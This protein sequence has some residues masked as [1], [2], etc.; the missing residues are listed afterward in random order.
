MALPSINSPVICDFNTTEPGAGSTDQ[1]NVSYVVPSFHGGFT[2]PCPPGAYN[3]TPGFT[4]CAGTDEAHDLAVL[5][6]KGMAVAGWKVLADDSV[7]KNV[8]DDFEEDKKRV[9]EEPY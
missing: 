5:T 8:W 1:G 9:G 4:A 7:A 6:S 2:I 3:H